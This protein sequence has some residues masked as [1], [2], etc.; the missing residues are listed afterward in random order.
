MRQ[1]LYGSTAGAGNVKV[2]REHHS[3]VHLPLV[4]AYKHLGVQQQ[5]AGGMSEELRYRIG[6]AR[7]AF[8]EA[9]RKIFRSRG[10][11]LRRRA[12][13]LQTLVLPASLKER[14]LGL[15]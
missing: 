7:S 15:S 11:S 4:A 2:L 14:D 1:D 6:Q 12:F 3:L 13:L 9:R 5:P 10:I 8:Q